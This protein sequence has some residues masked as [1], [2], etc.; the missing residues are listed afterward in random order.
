V[1]FPG[2]R[3]TVL[4]L[5]LIKTLLMQVKVGLTEGKKAKHRVFIDSLDLVFLTV[6]ACVVTPRYFTLCHPT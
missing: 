3:P 5:C 6:A 1:T 2:E 4:M